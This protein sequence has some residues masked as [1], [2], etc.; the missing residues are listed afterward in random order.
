M[1]DPRLPPEF[2]GPQFENVI[3]RARQLIQAR[4]EARSVRALPPNAPTHFDERVV[5]DDAE[6]PRPPIDPAFLDKAR[7][8]AVDTLLTTGHLRYVEIVIASTTG[9][10]SYLLI[11]MPSPSINR[12]D[13]FSRLGIHL[14]TQ[15]DKR[16]EDLGEIARASFASETWTV[17]TRPGDPSPTTDFADDPRR[18]E[19]LYIELWEEETKTAEA[20]IYEMIR[21][22]S[23]KV[24]DV[25]T[26][27]DDKGTARVA[28]SHLADLI[29]GYSVARLLL[30]P[31]K[32]QGER[33][34]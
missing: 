28:R 7:Q 14:A 19:S 6:P 15:H 25:V 34:T 2:R 29:D 20:H 9:K 23:G 12:R 17:A 31:W 27:H 30:A 18:V 13:Y 26:R 11:D 1:S 16:D 33:V 32:A 4:R 21:D 22:G 5:Y 24:T 10:H 3:E 8:R